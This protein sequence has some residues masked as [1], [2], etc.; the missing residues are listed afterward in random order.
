MRTLGTILMANPGQSRIGYFIVLSRHLGCGWQDLLRLCWKDQCTRIYIFSVFRLRFSRISV[1]RPQSVR[2][3]SKDIGG[4]GEPAL[5]IRHRGQT[6][7]EVVGVGRD[8][9]VRIGRYQRLARGRA[10]GA[11]ELR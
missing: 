7:E 3:A 10:G 8:V 4:G 5:R 2:A 11:R 6:I 1:V 9:A